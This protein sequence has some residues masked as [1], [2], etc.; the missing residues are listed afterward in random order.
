MAVSTLNHMLMQQQLRRGD[1]LVAIPESR[2]T[3]RLMCTGRTKHL[4]TG[5]KLEKLN[6]ADSYDPRF[7]TCVKAFIRLLAAL[8]TAKQS[9]VAAEDP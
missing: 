6:C 3:E 9:D 2:R 8:A 5:L 7:D 1:G 4:S